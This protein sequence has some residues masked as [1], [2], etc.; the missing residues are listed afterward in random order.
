LLAWL[1][2]LVLWHRRDLT[3]GSPDERRAE[4]G[5]QGLTARSRPANSLRQSVKISVVH[6]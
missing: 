3:R 6:G 1:D 4:N 2:F 5:T